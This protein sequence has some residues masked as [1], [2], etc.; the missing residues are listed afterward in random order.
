METEDTLKSNIVVGDNSEET[1]QPQSGNEELDEKS[2]ENPKTGFKK[3]VF[4]NSASK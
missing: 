4:L 3:S 2:I 1:N